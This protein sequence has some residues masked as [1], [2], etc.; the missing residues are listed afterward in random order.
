MTIYIDITQ[1]DRG[2]Q[3]TGIQRVVKEVLKRIGDAQDINYVILSYNSDISV[4]K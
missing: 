2:R 1:L 4:W 3:N